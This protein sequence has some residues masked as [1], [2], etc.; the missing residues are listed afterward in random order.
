MIIEFRSLV[1]FENGWTPPSDYDP[2]RLFY[3]Q[4]AYA[5]FRAFEGED[6]QQPDASI[7]NDRRRLNAVKEQIGNFDE[8][9]GTLGTRR[10]LSVGS[11]QPFWEILISSQ[12]P[13]IRIVASD[14]NCPSNVQDDLRQSAQHGF[15]EAAGIDYITLDLRDLPHVREVLTKGQFETLFICSCFFVVADE[16]WHNFLQ[17]AR[18]H[19]IRHVILLHT[20]AISPLNILRYHL[21]GANRR[22]VLFGYLRSSSSVIGLFRRC[23]YACRASAL[24]TPRGALWRK[25]LARLHFHYVHRA[26]V[27]S[28]VSALPPLR[29]ALKRAVIP[30]PLV[31]SSSG[32]AAP[33]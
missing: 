6:I 25:L 33:S 27:F 15:P 16:H 30:P 11:G 12:A 14:I 7:W 13:G 24:P 28:N 4:R 21:F 23:G 20:E 31:R 3:D 1:P 22:G 26:Y 32:Q 17:L 9:L 19:G 10:M 5:D 29:Q 18:D 8:L 2:S